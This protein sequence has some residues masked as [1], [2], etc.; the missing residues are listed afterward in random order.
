MNYEKLCDITGWK[1]P[2]IYSFIDYDDIKFLVENLDNLQ[3]GVVFY[4]EGTPTLKL[5][6]SLYLICHR[7]KG[8]GLNPKRIMQL[9]LMKEVNEYLSIFPEDQ[10]HF[11]K[12]VMAN[13][14]LEQQI[15]QVWENNKSVE[16]QKEF[17]LLVKDYPFSGVMFQA[18][19]LK[20]NNPL[21][22]FHNMPENFKLKVLTQYVD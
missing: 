22:L 9:V 18:K 4:K 2:R 11:E 3:E 13:N 17:A 12:Y 14:I 21:H 15:V 16:D 1:L 6:N 7:L 19:K 5:K 8:E 10:E 20:S